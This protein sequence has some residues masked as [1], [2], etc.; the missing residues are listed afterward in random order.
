MTALL[1]LILVWLLIYVIIGLICWL[2]TREPRRREQHTAARIA[3]LMA[4][5]E[6]RAPYLRQMRGPHR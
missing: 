1:L 6:A 3:Q 4:E 2:D 5:I